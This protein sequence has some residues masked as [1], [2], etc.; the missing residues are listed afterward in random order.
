MITAVDCNITSSLYDLVDRIFEIE[1]EIKDW[2]LGYIY[3]SK[4]YR[5][6]LLGYGD[7]FVDWIL[8]HDFNGK[9]FERRGGRHYF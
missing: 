2:D 7:D 6:K 4:G 1:I 3:L 5:I 8:F 9:T